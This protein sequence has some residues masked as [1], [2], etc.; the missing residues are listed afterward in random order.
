MLKVQSDKEKEED[1]LQS[2]EIDRRLEGYKQ[3]RIIPFRL[4]FNE[5]ED[6]M[7]EK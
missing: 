7:R 4:S 1:K 3:D 2:D 6:R 5:L